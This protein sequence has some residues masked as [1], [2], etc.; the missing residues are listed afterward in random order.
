MKDKTKD[1][2]KKCVGW[3]IS[4]TNWIWLVPIIGLVSIVLDHATGYEWISAAGSIAIIFTI[5]KT[6]RL[7]GDTWYE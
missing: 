1:G 2:R 4:A 6:F 3:R 5:L 7:V